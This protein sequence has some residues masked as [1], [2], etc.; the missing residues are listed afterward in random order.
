MVL[1]PYF[2]AYAR[3]LGPL[4]RA[5]RK[6]AAPEDVQAPE[7]VG[8]SAAAPVEVP[9]A[10]V[11]E[12]NEGR[13]MDA[14]ARFSLTLVRDVMTPRPDVVALPASGTLGDLRRLMR[15]TK[16]SRIPVYG[17]NLDDVVGVVSVRDLVEYEGPDEDAL[18]PL[19][20]PVFLVPETKKVA[21]LLKE[22]QERRTTFAVVIDEYG[23]TA[24][25][26]SVED[27][28]EELVGE[29]KDEYDAETEPITLEG[30]GSL[31]VAG[32]VNIQRLEQALETRL[33]NG[34]DV[35]TVGGLVTTVFGRVPRPGES[36]DFQGFTVEVVDAERK[37]VNRVRFKRKLAESP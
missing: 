11:H 35:G 20:R 34:E 16:Y 19:V 6:R 14:V 36:L 13:L 2:H 17:E 4:V 21:D 10:P 33:A 1:L 29:I 25:L 3:V 27:I 31:L 7:E 8:G 26:C 15:E 30:D 24:G 22:L 32:R 5:L 23:G 18:R 9:P 28:V 12:A 37:R